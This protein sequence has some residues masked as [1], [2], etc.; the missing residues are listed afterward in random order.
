MKVKDV[1]TKKVKTCTPETNLAAAAESMWMRDCGVL[2]IV[3]KSGR[4]VGMITDR[5]ICIAVGC[6][7]RDPAMILVREVMAEQ[8]YS[9]SPEADVCEA[10]Q[11][12][13][14]K[15]V[16]R[17]PVIDSAGELSGVISMNDIA[18]KIQPD[19]K[20][21]EPGLRDIHAALKS[22]CAHRTTTGEATPEQLRAEGQEVAAK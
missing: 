14:R 20:A 8:V 6:R 16:R 7:R 12:M 15:Q 3:D 11:I 5:D 21:P 2:P 9:C 22:I 10:L 19:A 13:K 17:L 1:M 18:L 4:V